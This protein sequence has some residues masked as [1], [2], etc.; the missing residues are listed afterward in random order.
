[1]NKFVINTHLKMNI[2]MAMRHFVYD[3]A[4]NGAFKNNFCNNPYNK[5]HRFC[6]E[7]YLYIY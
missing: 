5:F 6:R 1:M 3:I 4:N 2:P 7:W